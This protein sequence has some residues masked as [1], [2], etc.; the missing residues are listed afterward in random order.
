MSSRLH[1]QENLYAIAGFAELRAEFI[2]GLGER[3]QLLESAQNFSV[4]AQVLHRL[5]GA[6]RCYGEDRLA[7]I[8]DELTLVLEKEKKLLSGESIEQLQFGIRSLIEDCKWE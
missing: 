4:Q 8:V 1:S 3:L 7:Q 6:A 2:A 5:L